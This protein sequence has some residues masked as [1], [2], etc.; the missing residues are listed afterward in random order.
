METDVASMKRRL[1]V[2]VFPSWY[3][4]PERPWASTFVRDMAEAVARLHDV[5]VLAPPSISAQP[6]AV[7]NGVHTIRLP[8][9][10]RT[11]RAAT[12]L[13]LRALDRA[14]GRLEEQGRRP[15]LVHADT[16][17]AGALA[18]LAC[19]R[20]RIPWVLTEHFSG[21][22]AGSLSRWEA[23]IARYA[24]SRAARVFPV[25]PRLAQAI[26]ELEP[27]ARCEVIPD[28][29]AVEEFAA[30]PR[31]H[32]RGTRDRVLV[33]GVSKPKGIPT[34]LDAVRILAP[35]RPDLL[36]EIVGEGP[37]RPSYEQMAHGLPVVFV[38]PLSRRDIALKMH[39]ADIFAM[40]STV[41]CFG[42]SAIEA[43]CSG[44]PVVA[45][46]THGSAEV[47]QKHGGIVVPPLDAAALADALSNVLDSP[48]AVSD[49]ATQALKAWCGPE[50]VAHRYDDAYGRVLLEHHRTG[51]SSR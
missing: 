8:V 30:Q 4:S 14:M 22:L 27:N 15:D 25:S 31:P 36:V 41:E 47:I 18:A 34:L 50:A 33:V 39:E 29:V 12:L 1:H 16:F 20:R 42:I 49:E 44:L 32:P 48:T 9:E 3:P 40:P 35:R 7:E 46:T 28:V 26:L 37:E 19:R 24:Y 10:S 6:D 13:R 17:A 11:G 2:L 5:T 21:V 43:I 45:T 51:L 38:G 23:W